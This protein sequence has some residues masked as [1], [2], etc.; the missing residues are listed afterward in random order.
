MIVWTG[1]EHT[2]WTTA[3][4]AFIIGVLLHG[5]LSKEPL[6]ETNAILLWHTQTST[7]SHCLVYE[8]PEYYLVVIIFISSKALLIIEGL[9]SKFDFQNKTNL[10]ATV[11]YLLL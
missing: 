9:G 4:W 1:N 11:Q 7:L 5:H 3:S 8:K 10:S 2:K 6:E